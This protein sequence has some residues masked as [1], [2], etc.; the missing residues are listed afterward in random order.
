MLFRKSCVQRLSRLQKLYTDDIAIFPT[1]VGPSYIFRS[2]SH[3]VALSI[4]RVGLADNFFSCASKPQSH[5]LL[6]RLY[7]VLGSQS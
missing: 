6:G 3:N 2:E 1:V 4:G 7:H 5:F